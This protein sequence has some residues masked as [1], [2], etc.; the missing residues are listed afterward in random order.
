MTL[1]EL[2][3]ATPNA[4]FKQVGS[5]YEHIF[6]AIRSPSQ[7]IRDSAMNALRATLAVT[8]FRERKDD[9]SS[10]IPTYYQ[11]CLDEAMEGFNVDYKEKVAQREDRI[12]GSLMVLNEMFRCCHSPAEKIIQETEDK[13][14]HFEAH[15]RNR[16]HSW[17]DWGITRNLP[18][19]KH[20]GNQ[21]QQHPG[22][23]LKGLS[24]VVTHH[25]R[26]GNSPRMCAT[27][28]SANLGPFSHVY[29]SIAR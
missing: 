20:G 3:I 14:D 18:G 22:H 19:M 7:L 21:P 29:Q 2:A 27:L 15:E 25:K 23:G 9:H 4:Y 13:A 26:V 28:S 24:Q 16:S 12:H 6:E 5:F 17:R 10:Q 8:A 11:R 1:K